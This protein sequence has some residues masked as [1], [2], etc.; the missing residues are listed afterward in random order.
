M[1]RGAIITRD[2]RA[3]N[4]LE[5]CRFG[6]LNEVLGPITLG[7][8]WLRAFAGLGRCLRACARTGHRKTQ[9]PNNT[10]VPGGLPVG[11]RGNKTK[12]SVPGS[13][14]AGVTPVHRLQLVAVGQPSCASDR[15][16]TCTVI[17]SP[18]KTHL[19]LSACLSSRSENNLERAP[20]KSPCISNLP[21][22]AQP[23]C[24]VT[25]CTVPRGAPKLGVE[26]EPN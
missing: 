24:P 9:R 17:S 15:G 16:Q 6:E 7:D 13:S 12:Q 5:F 19:D 21:P 4:L 20:F 10:R 25:D 26:T 22:A 23:V 8:E 11:R 2:T 18:H 14:G 3:Q 1:G